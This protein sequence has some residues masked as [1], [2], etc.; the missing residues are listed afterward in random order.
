LYL[1][2]ATSKGKEERDKEKGKGRLREG[3][4][5]K[6]RGKKREGK[7]RD[8]AD[9]YSASARAPTGGFA[10]GPHWGSFDSHGIY[11]D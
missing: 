10:F 4:E 1:T 9:F 2:G 6:G 3:N 11:S 8:T 5:G 7:D